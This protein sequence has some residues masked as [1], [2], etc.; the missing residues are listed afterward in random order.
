MHVEMIYRKV[1]ARLYFLRQLKRA[2]VPAN[3]PL[4]FYIRPLQSMHVQSFI[5]LYRNISPIS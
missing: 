1:A 4:S 3:D 5:P 2:K